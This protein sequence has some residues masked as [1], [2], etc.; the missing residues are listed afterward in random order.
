MMQLLTTRDP[1]SSKTQIGW[2]WKNRKRSYMQGLIERLIKRKLG[3]PYYCQTKLT[4]GQKLL[5]EHYILM[6][7]NSVHQEEI[8]IINICA[9]HLETESQNI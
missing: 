9:P 3:W 6:M 7:D 5:W 4:S 1:F 2:K 8:T